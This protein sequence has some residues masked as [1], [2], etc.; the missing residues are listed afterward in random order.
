MDIKDLIE[1]A[2]HSPKRKAAC[3]G[4]EYSS[5]CP[6]CKDGDDRFLIWPQR[7]NKNGEFQGG[8]YSCRVCGKYG[9]SITFLMDL[10]DISYLEACR[11]LSLQPKSRPFK[12]EMQK[13]F[14]PPISETPAGAWIEKA[15]IFVDWCHS[16]L[17]KCP[18]ALSEVML[19]G[20]STESIKRYK[21]G[22]NP[23]D[24]Q[25][26][27]FMRDRQEWGLESSFKD[28]ET[29]RKL[30]LPVGLTIPTLLSDGRVIKVKVR[31]IN[32]EKEMASYEKTVTTG[33]KPKWKPQKYIVIS[34]SKESP[35]IYGAT[36][37]RTALVLES[38]LDALLVQQFAGDLLYCVALGGS[39]KPIDAETD[40]LLRRTQNVLFLP[41]F[42]KA[43]AVAWSKWKKLMPG[44]KRILTP[45]EKSAGDYFLAGGDLRDWFESILSKEINLGQS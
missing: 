10:Y 12:S 37:L 26:R 24:E 31:N 34:G 22:F 45:H 39:T 41:D 33:E 30:W 18:E 43:G 38:E 6:F 35:S 15:S 5:P 32:F 29:P 4:G 3:H 23:G 14:K 17:M 11:Q 44:I 36:S 19:R 40:A 2:G 7:C 28:D 16:K 21:L 27:G 8:R 1:E 13:P 42:D 9:D 25:G 20:F